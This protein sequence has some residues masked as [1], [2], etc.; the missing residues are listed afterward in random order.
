MLRA[1]PAGGF[2]ATPIFSVGDSI[3]DYRPPGVLD[4]LAVF[5]G[6]N[7]DVRLLVNHEFGSNAGYAYRLANGTQLTGSRISYFD[8]DAKTR[9]NYLL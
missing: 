3:G 7:G 6:V 8:I 1:T 4:G 9:H 5:P 2:R